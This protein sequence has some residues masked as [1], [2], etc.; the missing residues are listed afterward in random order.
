M[1]WRAGE[2]WYRLRSRRLEEGQGQWA[3]VC[4]VPSG[5]W[6][7]E[8]VPP[9]LNDL[10]HIS[11]RLLR[12]RHITELRIL[13]GFLAGS[14]PDGPP[15]SGIVSDSLFSIQLIIKQK[16]ETLWPDAFVQSFLSSN[17]H[18]LYRL[19][20]NRTPYVLWI[21]STYMPLTRMDGYNCSLINTQCPAWRLKPTP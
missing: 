2:R 18:G 10:P 12:S 17:L 13:L 1:H 5:G 11:S 6:K 3:S 14:P 19:F 21:N 9:R 20:S 15:L 8:V 16:K 7:N 4:G